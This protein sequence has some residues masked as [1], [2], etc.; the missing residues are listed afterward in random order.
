MLFAFSK[1]VLRRTAE[2]VLIARGMPNHQRR[3]A[4]LSFTWHVQKDS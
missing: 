2:G 1:E 3:D 4:S